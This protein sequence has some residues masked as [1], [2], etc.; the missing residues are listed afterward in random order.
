MN[1]NNINN[2]QSKSMETDLNIIRLR[3]LE[4]LNESHIT[5]LEQIY[6]INIDKILESQWITCIEMS[7]NESDKD[8][9]S[10]FDEKN[11]N[12][13]INKD[14]DD[15]LKPYLCA[16]HLFIKEFYTWKLKDINVLNKKSVNIVEWIRKD[17]LHNFNKTEIKY[18]N[19]FIKT[20]LSPKSIRESIKNYDSF[21]GEDISKILAIPQKLV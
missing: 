19:E 17:N 20:L 11:N 2:I 10:I 15:I 4:I 14:F 5:G 21:S 16:Y 9:C 12:I 3:W 8:L 6:P 13:Y 18:I 7:F 1:L